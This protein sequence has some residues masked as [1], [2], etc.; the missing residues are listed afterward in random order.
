MCHQSHEVLCEKLKNPI[1]LLSTCTG[2][3][4]ELV[5]VPI[6]AYTNWHNTHRFVNETRPQWS[7]QEQ[8][9]YQGHEMEHRLYI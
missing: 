1:L 8:T 5:Y 2:L 7:V 6:Y 4:Q 3:T 9:A